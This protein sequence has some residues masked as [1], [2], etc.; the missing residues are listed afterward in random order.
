MDHREHF[1]AIRQ[2]PG[3]YGLDGSFGQFSAYLAGFDAGTDGR[4]L[5]GFRE[6]LVGRLGT[7]DNLAWTGL[8]LHLAFP[9]GWPRLRERL[10]DPAQNAVA[11]STLFELLADFLAER[12]QPDRPAAISPTAGSGAD[13]HGGGPSGPDGRPGPLD[14]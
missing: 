7:G 13:R 3:L 6:W 4:A 12:E 10:T 9:G 8:V 2:R 14:R 11:V 5:D 1:A